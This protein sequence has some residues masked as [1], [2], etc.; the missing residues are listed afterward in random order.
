VITGIDS[1]TVLEQAVEAAHTFQPLTA[2]QV[3]ALRARTA[4]AAATG[5]YE[6]F[7]TSDRFDATAHHRAWLG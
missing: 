3:A 1:L 4:D 5:G 2:A 7:K 6:R